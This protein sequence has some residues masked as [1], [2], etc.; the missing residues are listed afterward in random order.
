MRSAARG[1]QALLL[2]QLLGGLLA[3]CTKDTNLRDT[4]ARPDDAA[5]AEAVIA[6]AE[7]AR[8]PSPELRTLLSS[9][10]PLVR[11]RALLGLGRV[12]DAQ[13]TPLLGPLLSRPGRDGAIAAWTLG[14]SHPDDD[15]AAKPASPGEAAAPR[16][17]LLLVDCLRTHCTQ[18]VEAARAL[19]KAGRGPAALQQLAASL[20]GPAALAAEAALALGIQAR[21][22]GTG[23]D[24]RVATVA[25]EPLWRALGRAESEVRRG[26]AYAL[27]RIPRA[28]GEL[29]DRSRAALV[30]AL[31]DP[32]AETRANA[33]RAAGRSGLA[34]QELAGLLG[35]RDWRV[36]VEAARALAF[37]PGALLLLG[38]ALRTAAEE[39]AREHE[40]GGARWAH[41]LV[42]LFASAA[43]LGAGPEL[44]PAPST[45]SGPTAASTIAVR[46]A[47]AQARDRHAHAPLETP[48]CG[49]GLEPPWRS[50]LRTAGL[51]ADLAGDHPESP[52]GAALLAALADTDP[53]VRSA[54]AQAATPA[55]AAALIERLDDPDPVVV[56]AAASSLAKDAAIAR[57]SLPAA[58][59]AATRLAS[60]RSAQTG[61]PRADS[62]AALGDLLAAAL[63][64]PVA[65]PFPPE[66]SALRPLFSLEPAPVESLP[67]FN[68]LSALARLLEPA[69]RIPPPPA[70][71][72][73]AAAFAGRP[74]QGPR[75]RSLV[76]ATTAGE[77]RVRLF[78]RDDETPLTAAALAA[79]AN[80]SFY[81]GLS[82]HRVVPDFV[83]QGGDPLGDGEGGPGWAIPDE[84]TPL[85]FLRG[86]LGLATSGPE[87]GGSQLFLCHAAEPHLDG[88]YTVA[89]QL[90]SGEAALD[91]LQVG[92][93]ILSA[94]AE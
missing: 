54:A 35:D 36:R 84:H 14:R 45:L 20:E 28:A 11:E 59:R 31:R 53:R 94:R 49:A 82:W 74:G 19:G 50:R 27:G 10:D 85:P 41:P 86:S 56:N 58:A 80:E 65:R 39:L 17:E 37:A 92:D 63:A 73:P 77:L 67:L 43:A 18:E 91:A 75:S 69:S 32:E 34:A 60:A 30:A 72:I 93:R 25:R 23:A 8:R 33:A 22:G 81:D 71:R 89:G 66:F 46:C 76:L 61:D 38:P 5:Q 78:T 15:D 6:Q 24:A 70:P 3:S 83:A 42:E 47:A 62:L 87:T 26:A 4:S 16:A 2:A 51:A 79:L 57:A 88:R 68:S 55:F 29:D 21:V 48:V 7:L 9:A 52:G 13:A 90:E 1:V 44:V 64:P 40:I 12:G